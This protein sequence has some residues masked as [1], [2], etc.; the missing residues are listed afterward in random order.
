M[1]TLR[2][3][4]RDQAWVSQ[5][6]ILPGFFKQMGNTNNVYTYKIQLGHAMNKT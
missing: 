2:I 4:G 5:Y 1:N 6:S 3:P